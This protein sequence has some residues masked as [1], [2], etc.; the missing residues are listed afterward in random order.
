MQEVSKKLVDF[1]F[2]WYSNELKWLDLNFSSML[3][4]SKRRATP[5]KFEVVGVKKL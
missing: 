5:F 4:A 3:A 1:C 2:V